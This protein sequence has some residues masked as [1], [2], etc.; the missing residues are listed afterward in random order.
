MT[1]LDAW[2][3]L[4]RSLGASAGDEAEYRRLLGAYA[5]PQRHYHTGQHLDECLD[6][7]AA[8]RSW[9]AHPAEVE[10]ALWFHDAIYEPRGRD[11]EARSAQWAVAAM[12]RAGLPEATMGRVEAL[13][14]TTCHDAVPEGADAQVL[15]D[16]DLW[17][18]AAPPGR[19][20]EYEGQIRAEYAWV[21][22][23]SFREKRREVLRGFLQRPRLFQ[24]DL[25]FELYEARARANLAGAVAE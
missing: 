20:A 11:N 14:M 6:N 21:P 10:L 5:E 18:L 2:H 22:E 9:A 24:T 17:I 19:F 8:L 15:V 1:T 25:Y 3:D 23:I 13:I 4:W 16:V 12:A 7:F